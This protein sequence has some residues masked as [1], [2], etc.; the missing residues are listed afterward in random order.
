MSIWEF[1]LLA[2]IYTRTAR[3]TMNLMPLMMFIIRWKS[4]SSEYHY[5]LCNDVCDWSSDL[6][7]AKNVTDVN[8]YSDVTSTSAMPFDEFSFQN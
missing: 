1:Y 2:S 4:V 6:N 8:N 3:P 7:G 5:F